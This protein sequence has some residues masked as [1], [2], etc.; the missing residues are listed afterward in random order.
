MAKPECLLFIYYTIFINVKVRKVEIQ[1][2]IQKKYLGKETGWVWQTDR[3]SSN[4]QTGSVFT[5][6]DMKVVWSYTKRQSYSKKIIRWLQ[7]IF[8]H[9]CLQC[10][11]FSKYTVCKLGMYFVINSAKD[12]EVNLMAVIQRINMFLWLTLLLFWPKTK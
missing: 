7:F 12:A 5:K 2:R 11:L 1:K 3:N 8:L 4:Y 6:V 9:G 10:F